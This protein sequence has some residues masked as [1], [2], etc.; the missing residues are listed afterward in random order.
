MQMEGL[1]AVAR[2]RGLRLARQAAKRWWQA[3]CRAKEQREQERRTLEALAN[4]HVG[5]RAV[6][7]KLHWAPDTLRK[8]EV[9]APWPCQY[10]RSR[11]R[12]SQCIAS[13]VDMPSAA[14]LSLHMS[15]SGPWPEHK[16][17]L[18]CI[19]A[20]KLTCQSPCRQP[21]QLQSDPLLQLDRH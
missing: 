16:Q 14:C 12:G 15:Q 19:A 13:R 11:A 17:P 5:I 18:R 1:K 8:D 3:V 7:F 6:P 4:V 2:K 20:I 9:G 21:A 10:L